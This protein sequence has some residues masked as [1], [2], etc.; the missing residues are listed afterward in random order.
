[1]DARRPGG[2][3]LHLSRRMVNAIE[4]RYDEVTRE[5][6]TTFRKTTA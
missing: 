6:R 1:V 3:G 2:L 4:Y 5:S